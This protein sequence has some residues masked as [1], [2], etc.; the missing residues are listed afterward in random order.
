MST[1]MA[2]LDPMDTGQDY[3]TGLSGK[4]GGFL[5]KLKGLF[6]NK[7]FAQYLSAS[8]ADISQTG[9]LGKNLNS[10]VQGDISSQNYA[11]MMQ[12][13]L[14]G[15]MPG[16]NASVDDKGLSFKVARETPV[17]SPGPDPGT[18]GVPMISPK[19][20]GGGTQMDSP[21]PNQG[22]FNPFQP[23]QLNFSAS[24]LAGLT[25]E[26]MQSVVN[27]KL[28]MEQMRQK[29]LNDLYEHHRQTVNDAMENALKGIQIENYKSEDQR[30]QEE[31]QIAWFKAQKE[32]TPADEQMYE[33]DKENN[34]FKGSLKE[35]KE[36][37]SADPTE[38]RNYELAK[39]QGF[40]GTFFDYQLALK[41][42]GA[43][44]IDL[45]GEVAKES[46]MDQLK[47]TQYLGSDKFEND[48]DKYMNTPI[49]RQAIRDSVPVKN[50][51][52]K[53]TSDEDYA[54]GEDKFKATKRK[55][56]IEQYIQNN[57]GEI[58]HEQMAGKDLIVIIKWAE[59]KDKEGK[60]VRPAKTEPFTYGI[61]E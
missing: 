22:Q 41:K 21:M 17:G 14:S 13:V 11:K 59:I 6:S 58:V 46:A 57:K 37:S 24:D 10:A 30:R 56:F 5:D 23:G 3:D 32:T 18:T 47:K 12:R 40:K 52:G 4:G 45:A 28:T 36:K 39:S 54:I 50:A 43:T 26:M 42:A 29:S 25:P 61:F 49:M 60:V 15:Q 44:K 35:W 20:T 1:N 8:G 51:Q 34:G 7:M 16:V 31:S 9:S 33:Y 19:N 2:G 48:L 27:E 53:L 38:Q 55:E